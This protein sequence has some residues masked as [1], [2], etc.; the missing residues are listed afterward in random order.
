MIPREIQQES[1]FQVI[2]IKNKLLDF[3]ASLYLKVG[4]ADS[5]DMRHALVCRVLRFGTLPTRAEQRYGYF[6]ASLS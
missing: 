2:P 5:F 3:H 1:L 6:S 4:V